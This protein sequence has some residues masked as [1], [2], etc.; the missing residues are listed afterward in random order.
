V[1]SAASG[2]V[3]PGPVPP[4]PVAPGPVAPGSAPSGSGPPVSG[5]PGPVSSGAGLPLPPAW[6]TGLA[7]RAA[8]MRVP[9]RLRA[10]E[11]GGRSSAVLLLFGETAGAP[12]LLIVQRG[13]HLRR[14]AG[15]PAF[16]GGA[17]EPSDSGPVG[18]A[19]REAAEEVGADPAGVTVLAVLPELFI[20]RSGFRV[21]P[22][23]AWWHTP[24]P[25]LAAADGEIVSAARVRLADLADP[26]NRLS[27]RHPS[28]AAGP[29][30]RVHGMLVWGFTALLVD[31]LLALGGWEQPWDTGREENLPPDVLDAAARS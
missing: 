2:P 26:A 31:R 28:G 13:A 17:I 14:H 20:P 21:T 9:P 18:A 30:F 24:S 12:D 19:L 10:P 7:A 23:L 6:L 22:V 25:L 11:Q 8:E 3:P 16:P 29:A 15:Q 4:G 27:V 5:P 1:T